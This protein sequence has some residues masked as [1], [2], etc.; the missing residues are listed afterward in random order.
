MLSQIEKAER[1]RAL[2]LDPHLLV[3]VNVWDVASAQAVARVAG[4]TAIATASA[5]VAA[6]HGY[7]DGEQ[8]PPDLVFDSL[9]R[10]CAAVDLPV[11][12]DLE[13]GY[14][15]PPDTIAQAL[16]AGAV[17]YT[18]EDAMCPVA[19]M[20]DRIAAAVAV[21]GARGIPAV[22]NARTDVYL[23]HREWPEERRYAEARHRG[24]AY[25]E[26]GADCVFVP[27]LTAGASIRGLVD[28]FGRGRL[29]L[30]TAVGLPDYDVLRQWGVARVSHG[31]YPHR[32]AM[33]A[34]A[35]YAAHQLDQP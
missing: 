14:A 6:A 22:L 24:L 16:D 13:R 8:I 4:C 25:L 10:I 34:L 3:L 33:A 27:G 32:Q 18:L 29:S 21:G 7:A 17:G 20:T 1:L 2:H 28:A 11:T 35:T 26:A 23:A 19:E 15:D 30:I 9:R 5:A 12:A 31:P